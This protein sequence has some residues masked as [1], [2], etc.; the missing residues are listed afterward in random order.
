MAKKTGKKRAT[1]ARKHAVKEG[2]IVI[3]KAAFAKLNKQIT[4]FNATFEKICAGK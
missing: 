3:P 1:G 2:G 4:A